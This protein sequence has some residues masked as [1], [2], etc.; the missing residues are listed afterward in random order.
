M[1][2][3]SHNYILSI[4]HWV[5][6]ILKLICNIRIPKTTI[7]CCCS[8]GSIFSFP[9]FYI[10]PSLFAS[11]RYLDVDKLV[12]LVVGG[13][14]SGLFKGGLGMFGDWLLLRVLN[15]LSLKSIPNL[16]LS[17]RSPLHH[18]HHSPF[19]TSFRRLLMHSMRILDFSR[20]MA[21]CC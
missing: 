15:G 3:R 21:C 10:I 5:I 13:T 6:V 16:D 14:V 7:N 20:F 11:A 1:L 9:H 12:W 19:L 8:G 18:N 17:L 4:S 2:T